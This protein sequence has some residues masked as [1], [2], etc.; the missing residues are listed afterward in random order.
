MLPSVIGGRVG[1]WGSLDDLFGAG[2]QYWRH[3]DAKRPCGLE[4]DGQFKLG[5]KL[6]P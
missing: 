2:E 5:R 1:A 4:I 3:D 6:D